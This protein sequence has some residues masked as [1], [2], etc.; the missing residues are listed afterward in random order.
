MSFSSHEGGL[1]VKF[2]TLTLVTQNS[3]S[4]GHRIHISGHEGVSGPAG[5]GPLILDWISRSQNLDLRCVPTTRISGT[6]NSVPE[7]TD[8]LRR[9]T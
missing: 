2:P 7:S 8:F 1:L 9:N 4:R 5:P 3:W 6:E